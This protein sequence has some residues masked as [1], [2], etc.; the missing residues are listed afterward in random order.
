MFN[1]TDSSKKI[2]QKNVVKLKQDYRREGPA[3]SAMTLILNGGNRTMLPPVHLPRQFHVSWFY[4][5]SAELH[6]RRRRPVKAVEGVDEF[7]A[8]LQE[9]KRRT[10]TLWKIAR[11]STSCSSSCGWQILTTHHISKLVHLQFKRNFPLLVSAVMLLDFAQVVQVDLL[12]V[13]LLDLRLVVLLMKCL[14]ENTHPFY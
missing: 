13:A 3:G 7:M 1:L 2:E 10:H 4:E 5:S 8:Q 11:H 9:R 12:P 14:R 6:S